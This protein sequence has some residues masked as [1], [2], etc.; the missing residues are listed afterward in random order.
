MVTGLLGWS[1]SPDA[2]LATSPSVAEQVRERGMTTVA[3]L[4][5]FVFG[6]TIGSFLNVV[7]HRMPIGLTIVSKPSRCPYCMTPIRP[8][9]NVP[10]LGWLV[11][12]GRCNA[13]GLPISA[14]YVL[15]E[16]IMGLV[17]VSLFWAELA[18]GG[19]NLPMRPPSSKPGV[20][21]NLFTPQWDLIGLYAFHGFL[22]GVLATIALIKLDQL[23]IPSKLFL[24]AL[25]SG[26]VARIIWPFLL[27]VPAAKPMAG[28]PVPAV[29][30]HLL[31]DLGVAVVIGAVL[32]SVIANAGDRRL[33]PGVCGSLAVC[34][35]TADFLGWQALIPVVLIA[36]LLQLVITILGRWP[37]YAT[38]RFWGCSLAVAVWLTICFW[39]QLPLVW[40]PGAQSDA[41]TQFLGMAFGLAAAYVAE[42]LA[43]RENGDSPT[44]T[45]SETG[46]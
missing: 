33:V 6:T 27:V 9:H 38:S 5:F 40:I 43:L 36:A 16:I 37:G 32:Q 34:L 19:R 45:A 22:L 24:F 15:V 28:L 7:A 10:V 46:Q 13:C 18:S 2:P 21:W 1:G 12:R 17:F 11:L 35:V 31:V 25:V 14:R 23:K 20:M 29:A 30:Q 8:K 26:S 4:W 3:G 44:R 41:R 42:S 39:R